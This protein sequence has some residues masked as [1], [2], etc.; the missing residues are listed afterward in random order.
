MELTEELSFL[1][2]DNHFRNK[3]RNVLN[4][5]KKLFGNFPLSPQ[6][7]IEQISSITYRGLRERSSAEYLRLLEG[8]LVVEKDV[9]Y[10]LINLFVDQLRFYE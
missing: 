4:D 3:F 7:I 9:E 2:I 1:F 8:E 6:N 5:L 10:V